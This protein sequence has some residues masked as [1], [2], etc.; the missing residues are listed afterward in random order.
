MVE[1]LSRGNF[2]VERFLSSRSFSTYCRQQQGIFFKAAFGRFNEV[3]IG[4]LLGTCS[5]NTNLHK[6]NCIVVNVR[7]VGLEVRFKMVEVMTVL[8]CVVSLI[9]NQPGESVGFSDKAGDLEEI[10]GFLV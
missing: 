1:E 9:F 5:F 8:G 7:V 6:K 2:V 3:L 4:H 10:C